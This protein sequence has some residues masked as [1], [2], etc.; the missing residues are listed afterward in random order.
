MRFDAER[1]VQ[2]V[3]ADIFAEEWK[4]EPTHWGLMHTD[5]KHLLRNTAYM[6]AMSGINQTQG[7][8]LG[9]KTPPMPSFP[10]QKLICFK[11]FLQT[12]VIKAV[13][14]HIFNGQFKFYSK[15]QKVS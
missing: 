3:F 2:E 1:G 6:P 14:Y 13:K 5:A 15:I 8:E 10:D 11:P 12:E 4:R 9:L 7:F